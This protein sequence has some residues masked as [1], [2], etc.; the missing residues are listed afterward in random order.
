MAMFRRQE[1]LTHV[2]DKDSEKRSECIRVMEFDGS[3]LSSQDKMLFAETLREV[4]QVV[5]NY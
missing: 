5:N 4:W 1:R 3:S 2:L